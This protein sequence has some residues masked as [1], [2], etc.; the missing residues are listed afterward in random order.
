MI[1]KKVKINLFSKKKK[2]LK[3][4][5]N[6]QKKGCVKKHKDLCLLLSTLQEVGVK[7]QHFYVIKPQPEF[8]PK[9]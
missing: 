6:L 7:K 9:K 1:K 4:V 3:L 5:D 2:R 8:L